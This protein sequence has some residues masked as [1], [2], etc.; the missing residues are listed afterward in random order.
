M[1]MQGFESVPFTNGSANSIHDRWTSDED[2]GC[3][4]SGSD[5]VPYRL[6]LCSLPKPGEKHFTRRPRANTRSSDLQYVPG[7]PV[8]LYDGYWDQTVTE[9]IFLLWGIYLCYAVRTVPSA[10]HEPRYMA[11]A[12]HIEL[13][14]SA[15]FHTIRQVT[16]I[17]SY[18][19]TV[20]FQVSSQSAS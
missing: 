13:I 5:L 19:L 18:F 15:I 14:I 7:G 6:D 4:F 9:F 12:V 2:A 16:Y 1:I 20:C 8:G 11:V 17:D 10:F 3:D